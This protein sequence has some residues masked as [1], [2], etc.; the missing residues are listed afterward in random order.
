MMQIPFSSTTFS[1]EETQAVALSLSTILQPNDVILFFGDLGAGKT[2]FIQGLVDGLQM[3]KS[4]IWTSSPTFSYLNI[5][6]TTPAIYHFDLYRLYDSEEFLSVGFDEYFYAGGVCCIE[7][8]ERIENILPCNAIHVTLSH[9]NE[10]T[11]HI[12]ILRKGQ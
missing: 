8:S 1:S 4:K 6:P 11:R 12:N 10:T 3:E 9:L 7:W 5:Y 2:T